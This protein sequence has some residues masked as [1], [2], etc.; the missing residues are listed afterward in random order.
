[1]QE[2]EGGGEFNF[3]FESYQTTQSQNSF[4]AAA[5]LPVLSLNLCLTEQTKPD[6]HFL[7]SLSSLLVLPS[8]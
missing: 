8:C 4:L 3:H 1:M 7:Y 6:I 5:P 2:G